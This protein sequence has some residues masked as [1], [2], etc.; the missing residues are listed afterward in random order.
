MRNYYPT[1]PWKEKVKHLENVCLVMAEGGHTVQYRKLIISRV[2]ARYQTSLQ[3]HNSRK[4]KMYRTKLEREAHVRTVCK[5][6]MADWFR[7]GG[8]INSLGI[9]TTSGGRLAALVKETLEKC[10]APG[11]NR[12]KVVE[13][14]C[15]SVRLQLVRSNPFPRKSCGRENCPL[16]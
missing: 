5:S 4:K 2:L 6:S 13:R 7:K 16:R 11:S 8:Y 1:F 9:P 10:P 3:N 12:T 14:G 15:R